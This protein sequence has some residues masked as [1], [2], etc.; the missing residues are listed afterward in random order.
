M[1]ILYILGNGFDKAQGM[2]T[3]YPDF[4]QYLMKTN[5][6]P[7]LEQM[8]K[9][10]DANEELWSDMEEAFGKFTNKIE[11]EDDFVRLY[12]ELSG[13]LREYLEKEEVTF[14]PSTELRL[15]LLNDF[16]SPDNYLSE[17]DKVNFQ[18]FCQSNNLGLH[19]K[20]LSGDT[21]FNVMTLN[22]T[23]TL[24]TLFSI[25]NAINT[26]SQLG[27]NIHSEGTL[28]RIIH[29]HGILN[30][31]II[32]GVDNETQIA[33]EG[34]RENMRVKDL[35]VK[36][37]SNENM[38]FNRHIICK[39]LIEQAHL[40]V[41]FGVSLGDT[42][43]RWWKLIGEQ[44]EKRKNLC[45]IQYLYEPQVVMP[46]QRQLIGHIERKQRGL[47]MKKMGYKTRPEWPIESE[48][49][50]LFVTNSDMFK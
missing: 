47:F 18:N 21:T 31:A 46:M 45:I 8:K 30:D 32:I 49:K 13:Y 27:L 14:N 17:I 38:K 20:Y 5:C 26:T 15:K 23:K 24:E 48:K 25:N 2:K 50:L 36:E 44:F 11:N 34:F 3:S 35:L 42:D 1:N 37:Q 6:S 4:Y 40:I 29:V 10:I 19:Y 43:N 33:N 12:F 28:D 41:L 16:A 39:D 9:E 22:Y 7:L